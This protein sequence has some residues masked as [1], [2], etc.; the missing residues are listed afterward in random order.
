LRR[1]ISNLERVRQKNPKIQ[2]LIKGFARE[3]SYASADLYAA[4]PQIPWQ[5]AEASTDERHR[6]SGPTA[7]ATTGMQ[8]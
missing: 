3:I 8:L 5:V 2:L 1:A 4:W 7:Q 6:K